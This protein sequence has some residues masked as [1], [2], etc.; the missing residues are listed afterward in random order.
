M[1]GIS[2]AIIVCFGLQGQWFLFGYSLAFSEAH[3]DEA[4]S[5]IGGSSGLAFEGVLINPV[6]NNPGARIPEIVYAF[7]QQMF[8]CFTLVMSCPSCS[9]HY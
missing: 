8:A 9:R 4:A 5:F 7:Y 2:G 3:N 1:S 6:G